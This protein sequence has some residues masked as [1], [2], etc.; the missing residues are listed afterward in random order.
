MA[1]TDDFN[2]RIIADF[3]ATQGHP[4]DPFAGTPI[5]LLHTTG[6]RS[7]NPRINPLVY[8]A[9][10]DRYL[11]FASYAGAPRDPAWYHNLKAYPEAKIEVDTRTLAVRVDEVT[12]AERDAIYARHA[13]NYPAFAEYEAK[14]GR[15]IPVI[16]L[17]PV[18][19]T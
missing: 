13:A 14:A 2:A 3:R 5:L 12:G 6:A 9:D 1:D 17:T 16:A 10:G 4:G 19:A 7:G 15:K 18:P 8:A 11:V